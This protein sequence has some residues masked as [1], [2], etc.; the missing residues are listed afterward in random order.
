MSVPGFTAQMSL[1]EKREHYRI[2]ESFSRERGIRGVVPQL[3]RS[4]A[5]SW[6]P[7]SVFC[8]CKFD[9][10]LCVVCDESGFCRPSTFTEV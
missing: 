2:V 1:C 6:H 10:C 5:Y 3:T 4:A 9:S 8:R 7:P